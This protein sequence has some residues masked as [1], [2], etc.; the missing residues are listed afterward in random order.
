MNRIKSETLVDGIMEFINSNVIPSI[1]D[2]FLKIAMKTAI[3]TAAA[4]KDA[5]V[6]MAEGYLNTDFFSALL[7]RDSEGYFEVENLIDA[8]RQAM[9]ECGELK[10]TFPAIKFLS[11]TEKV[12]I[13]KAND[14]TALK[15]YITNA[16]SK[17]GGSS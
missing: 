11:P 6:K 3:I 15:Q 9:N 2:T 14:I 8:I 5:Y 4:N 12:L 17:T 10:I 7:K 1:D 16:A 13:F